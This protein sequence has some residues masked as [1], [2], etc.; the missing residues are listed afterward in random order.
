MPAT[1]SK[2]LREMYSRIG[3]AYTFCASGGNNATAV[4]GNI[5]DD[6][7]TDTDFDRA[8]TLFVL[9]GEAE[10]QY[11]E[12]SSYAQDTGTFTLAAALTKN[13]TN[14]DLVTVADPS[15]EWP[16][17]EMIRAVNSG[18]SSIGRVPVTS[19]ITT[20]L[21]V[22]EYTVTGIRADEDILS[23]KAY[24]S[25]EWVY[26]SYWSFE[27]G[28][29]TLP[30]YPEGTIVHVL[31]LGEHPALSAYSDTVSEYIDG[32]LAVCA[33]L[34]QALRSYNAA[35]SMTDVYWTT[36]QAENDF[37]TALRL[38]PVRI[39]A[40]RNKNFYQYGRAGLL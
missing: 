19:I 35:R 8:G 2:I 36:Q 28:K 24:I 23:V 37:M 30:P 40:R 39:P 22:T 34:R 11:S 4:I 10:G 9:S 3:V 33:S 38:Y 14:G 32:E 21:G 6:M 20:L 31:Y 5:R 29:I 1:L 17:R 18:L 13:I 26:A 15:G 16:L 7:F 25:N 12:V 27:G